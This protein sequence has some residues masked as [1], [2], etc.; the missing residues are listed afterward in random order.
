MQKAEPTRDALIERIRTLEER[1]WEAEQTIEAIQTGEV[2]ALVVQRPDGEQLYTLE[3]AD[4]GYRILVESITEGA[5]IL[6][7]DDSIYYC[8]RSFGGML[9]LP[10]QKIISTKLDSYVVSEARPQLME[11]IKETRRRGATRGEILMKRND[12][13]LLPTNISLNSLSFK[14][15]EG[16]CAV[17]TDLSD[18]K[19]I[20]VDLKMHRTRLESLVDE[21]TSDL[22][23]SNAE[24]QQQV[25]ERKRVEMELRETEERLRASLG[26]KEVLLKEI[27]HRVKNNM[28]VISSLVALQADHLP[29]ESMRAVLREV[30]HRVRSMAMIHEKLYESADLARVDFAQYARSLLGY[31][32][33]AHGNVAAGVR[34]T[35]DLEPLTLPVNSAVPCGLILNELVSNALKHAFNDC[36]EGEVAISIQSSAQGRVRLSVRDNGKGMPAGFDWRE[37]RSL[38][39]RLVGMLAGQLRADVE[40]SSSGGTEFSI[41]FEGRDK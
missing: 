32:W 13:T 6:S 31:L 28:Q 14:G 40:V 22:V 27:H 18:Q 34:L 16:V 4:H 20:E 36:G 30:T 11:H 41:S 17:L 12:G 29:D 26:E 3:G 25:V 9:G 10:L 5:L 1:L 7:S 15:F 33:S 37:A 19:R 8:N 21:R 38:G 39:L 24:L 2:D 23:Q 35:L